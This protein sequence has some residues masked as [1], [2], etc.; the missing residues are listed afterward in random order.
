MCDYENDPTLEALYVKMQE[1]DHALIVAINANGYGSSLS[2]PARSKVQ[3]LQD[4][5]DARRDVMDN[6]RAERL[7]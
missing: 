4:L 1:A 6:E 2:D 7:G 5:I 3:R